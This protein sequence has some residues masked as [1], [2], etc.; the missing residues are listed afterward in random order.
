MIFLV[1]SMFFFSIYVD[2][3]LLGLLCGMFM[4]LIAIWFYS[5]DISDM[6]LFLRDILGAVNFGFG[7]FI[8]S[9][10]GVSLMKESVDGDDDDDY[11][12]A[13]GD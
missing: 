1:Y 4:L 7:A 13:I 5:T 10:V 9:A 11:V 3:K 6:S 2:N 12:F 8:V